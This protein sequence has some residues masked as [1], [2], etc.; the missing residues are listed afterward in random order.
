MNKT[1]FSIRK[2]FS[3]FSF[4]YGVNYYLSR[5]HRIRYFKFNITKPKLEN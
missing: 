1:E 4:R 3:I 5:L 2:I